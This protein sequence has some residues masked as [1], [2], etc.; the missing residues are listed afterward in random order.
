MPLINVTPP[1][2]ARRLVKLE[3]RMDEVPVKVPVGNYATSLVQLSSMVVIG[4]VA[5]RRVFDKR[6][7]VSDRVVSKMSLVTK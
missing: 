6:A 2:K 3:D 5:A 4:L 7:D 1:S